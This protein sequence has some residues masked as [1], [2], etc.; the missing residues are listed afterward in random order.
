[1][2]QALIIVDVQKDFCAGGSLA[3]SE[4]DS[5]VEPI[6]RMVNFFEEK[7]YPI[8]LT[9]DW[10]P[11]DHSSFEKGG[12]IWP[13]HC[14]AGSAGADF[15]DKLIVPEH[16]V[17]ISKATDANVDA[18]S[19]FDGTDLAERLRSLKVDSVAVAGLATDYCVKSTVL[20]AIKAG[21]NTAV[22]TDAV[23]AVNVEPDDGAKAIEEMRSAGART[24]VSDDLIR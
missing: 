8:F 7:G 9:R 14:V 13:P 18:Y 15:H 10:H 24:T 11:A 12:G 2:R 6:N 3:V 21:F 17:I 5:V 19:G 4:G 16:A 1:M 22:I 23:K 20:D